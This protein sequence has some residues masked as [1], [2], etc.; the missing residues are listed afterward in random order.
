M[1]KINCQGRL[2][3]SLRHTGSLTCLRPISTK[4]VQ[5]IFIARVQY[6]QNGYNLYSFTWCTLYI[7]RFP[8]LRQPLLSI[9]F[10]IVSLVST[11]FTVVHSDWRMY[12]CS[13]ISGLHIS[14]SVC[15]PAIVVCHPDS[16]T[17]E[18]FSNSGQSGCHYMRP[19]RAAVAIYS[20][21][22]IINSSYCMYL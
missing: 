21:R 22:I 15:S 8:P 3:S 4:W 1:P 11:V 9:D 14:V 7:F 5:F 12:T 20:T 19:L 17:F 18:R 6:L 10:H 16:A 13:I 2:I